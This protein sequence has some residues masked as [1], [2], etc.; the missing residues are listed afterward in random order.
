MG[1]EIAFSKDQ[2]LELSNQVPVI[3]QKE[4]WSLR[5]ERDEDTLFYSAKVI[6]KG[7]KL[8]SVNDE[9]SLYIYNRRPVGLVIDYFETNFNE[10]HNELR[11]LAKNIFD[12]RKQVVEVS[13]KKKE[14]KQFQHSLIGTLLAEA[15]GAKFHTTEFR[16]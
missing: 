13:A 9:F 16:T 2:L 5:L 10:H 1:N 12:S 11:E 15:H 4:H 8:Y 3:G 7:S 6:P 14:V